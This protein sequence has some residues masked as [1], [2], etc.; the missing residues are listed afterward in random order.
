MHPIP[1][2]D[3]LYQLLTMWEVHFH[4]KTTHSKDECDIHPPK[5][6][7]RN[8]STIVAMGLRS[9]LDKCCFIRYMWIDGYRRLVFENSKNILSFVSC[10]WFW[11]GKSCLLC[12][13]FCKDFDLNCCCCFWWYKRSYARC[14]L[15]S[16]FMQTKWLCG[17][18]L[19]SKSRIDSPPGNEDEFI[20]N[21]KKGFCF[22]A[23]ISSINEFPFSFFTFYTLLIGISNF[24]LKEMF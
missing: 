5:G 3:W 1:Y 13:V 18:D 24:W 12:P 16:N 11:F 9:R 7:G 22:M 23:R 15:Y 8:R 4:S 21:F 14:N 2:I 6:W 19:L 20:N 10:V 17:S